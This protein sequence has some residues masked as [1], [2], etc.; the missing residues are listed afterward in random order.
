MSYRT[1][2]DFFKNVR[3]EDYGKVCDIVRL[4]NVRIHLSR[5]RYLYLEGRLGCMYKDPKNSELGQKLYSQEL[6]INNLIDM[7]R[8]PFKR[9]K[10]DIPDNIWVDY[11]YNAYKTELDSIYS[12]LQ[13]EINKFKSIL[14]EINS[15]YRGYIP[16]YN[17]DSFAYKI[18]VVLQKLSSI[19]DK[20][21][22]SDTDECIVTRRY[23]ESAIVKGT[24]MLKHYRSQ[25]YK[26][27]EFF[28]N[29]N[30]LLIEMLEKDGENG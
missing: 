30:N 15:L 21:D 25:S 7:Y 20:I 19:Q 16:N 2:G 29:S 22:Y 17:E 24:D 23:I 28:I 8:G 3:F 11:I 27:F 13:P 5:I 26:D 6:V 14:L 10:K 9:H 1:P 18:R 4:E 12:K